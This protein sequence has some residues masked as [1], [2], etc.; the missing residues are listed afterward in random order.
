MTTETICENY[1]ITVGDEGTGVALTFDVDD[2]DEVGLNYV[3]S[4][5]IDAQGFHVELASSPTSNDVLPVL[6]P[7]QEGMEELVEE[8]RQ[9]YGRL[10]IAGLGEG[11]EPG[12][13]KIA[14]A[15]EMLLA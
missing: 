14:F 15:R 8:I 9:S 6:F 11:D 10:F 2:L 13:S 12:T 4:L 3:K 1:E 5:N 7:L